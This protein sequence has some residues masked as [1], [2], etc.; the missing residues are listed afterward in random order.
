[1]WKINIAFRDGKTKSLTLENPTEVLDGGVFYW[2]VDEHRNLY[3]PVELVESI[4]E[5]ALDE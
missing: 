1:M 4:E 3:I 5:V 2:D